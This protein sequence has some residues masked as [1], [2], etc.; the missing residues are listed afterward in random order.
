MRLFS[1]AACLA[2]A[3]TL[4]ACGSGTSDNT[5]GTGIGGTNTNPVLIPNPEPTPTVTLQNGTGT[6]MDARELAFAS[7]LYE[8]INAYRQGLA[9]NALTW[10]NAVAQVAATHT[11]EMQ[12]FGIL[13]HDAPDGSC[14]LPQDCL[15]QR[16]QNG[17]VVYVSA[18]ENLAR[19]FAAAQDI[20]DA[21]I[22]SPN[23]KAILDDPNW[24]A[25]GI[26][27]LEGASAANPAMTGAWVTLNCIQ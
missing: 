11:T 26:T 4:A 25:M 12:A 10:D 6:T 7:D 17:A 14:T 21:W 3:L 20:L 23:H 9:L 2:A 15:G 1:L 8:K 13:T 24:T 5:L 19:G 16:L 27:Y 22:A 18:G